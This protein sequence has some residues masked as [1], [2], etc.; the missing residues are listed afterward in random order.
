MFRGCPYI[1]GIASIVDEQQ[2]FYAAGDGGDDDGD[3]D[4]KWLSN[5]P[6]DS[7]LSLL[8]LYRWFNV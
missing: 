8:S 7:Q 3:D 2:T 5:F 6:R 4:K 1:V